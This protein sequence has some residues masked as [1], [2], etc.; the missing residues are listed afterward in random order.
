MVAVCEFFCMYDVSMLM[1]PGRPIERH[2]EPGAFSET[3]L[4]AAMTPEFEAVGR[5]EDDL[6]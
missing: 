1:A 2:D 4:S 3:A 6:N 5:I